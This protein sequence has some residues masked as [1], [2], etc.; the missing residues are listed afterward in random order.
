MNYAVYLLVVIVFVLVVIVVFLLLKNLRRHQ[1]DSRENCT[2]VGSS[3]ID[4]SKLL[5]DKNYLEQAKPT[6]TKLNSNNKPALVSTKINEKNHLLQLKKHPSLDKNIHSSNRSNNNLVEIN[7]FI[8]SPVIVNEKFV[9]NKKIDNSNENHS[10]SVLP[11]LSNSDSLIN[12]SNFLNSNVS[13]ETSD[14]FNN[15]E[16]S[17]STLISN[18]SDETTNKNSMT[19]FNS[20]NQRVPSLGITNPNQMK[21]NICYL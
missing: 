19:N 2:L 21:I 11:L 13:S 18:M 8:Q 4:Q 1:K 16:N 10:E 6:E 20:N 14:S 3:T 7:N 15:D 9:T 5:Y 17:K 12:Q